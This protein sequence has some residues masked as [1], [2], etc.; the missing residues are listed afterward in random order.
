MLL[1]NQDGGQNNTSVDTHQDEAYNQNKQF[2]INIG[3]LLT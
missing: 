1:N 2:K 3:S